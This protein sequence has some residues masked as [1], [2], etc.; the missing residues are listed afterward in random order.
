MKE[1]GP[2]RIVVVIEDD[3]AIRKAFQVYLQQ[4]FQ[5]HLASTGEEGVKLISSQAVIDLLI[6]D[7]DLRGPFDGLDMIR[8]MKKKHPN[9]SIILCTGSPSEVSRIG[10]A[11]AIPGIVLLAKPFKLE[12]LDHAI[13]ILPV[14]QKI[15]S[16]GGQ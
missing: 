3:Q 8:T 6:T 14:A 16:L 4:F 5:V 2:K 15:A 13:Q 10:Q 9:A 12:E 7:F 1:S 11:L